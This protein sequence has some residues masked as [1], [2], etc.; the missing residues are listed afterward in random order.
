[1]RFVHM[2]PILTPQTNDLTMPEVFSTILNK[3]ALSHDRAPSSHL[4]FTF[5]EAVHTI[6]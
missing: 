2:T 4:N 5:H 6:S 1:M 3:G